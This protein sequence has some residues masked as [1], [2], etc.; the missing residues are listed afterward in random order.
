MRN[1]NILY[2]EIQQQ[3]QVKISNWF[4]VLEKVDA[5]VDISG[6]RRS[7]SDKMEASVEMNI[8]FYG[9]TV[10]WRRILETNTSK[11]VG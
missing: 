3:P 2:E 6:A 5:C 1:I 9:Q 8:G 7:V 4:A 11:E 10:I